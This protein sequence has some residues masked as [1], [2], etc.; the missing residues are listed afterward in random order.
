M[1]IGCNDADIYNYPDIIENADLS[2]CTGR[3]ERANIP[4]QR[5]AIFLRNEVWP[6]A[7][8][9]LWRT[10]MIDSREQ[11]RILIER[12]R[13]LEQRLYDLQQT[14]SILRADFEEVMSNRMKELE[15][16]TRE[17]AAV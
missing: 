11:L 9:P 13:E 12:N 14:I 5:Q 17:A 8:R 1:N 4:A 15:D 7:D 2:G 3:V 16:L 10:G 6:P